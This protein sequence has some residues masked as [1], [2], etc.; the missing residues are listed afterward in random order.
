[1]GMMRASRSPAIAGLGMTDLGKVY[2]KTATQFAAEAVAL[3]A[4]DAGI[5]VSQ[6]DG[7]LISSGLKHRISTDLAQDLGLRD[8]SI[9]AEMNAFGATAAAM[10]QAAS[11]AVASGSARAV[12]CVFADTPLEEKSRAGAAYGDFRAEGMFGYSVA[13]GL[14]SAAAMY[15]LAARRHMEAYGT[16]KEQLGAVATSTRAWAATNERAQYRA[17][18]TLTDY[19]S[20]R[21]ISE[22][23]G[24]FDCC[25][26]S[27]GA[28]AVIV[29]STEL[30]ADGPH[31]AVNVV[32]WAQSHASHPM[33]TDPEFGIVTG[34]ATA[35]Q[36][37]FGRSGIAREE[38]DVAQLYDCFTYT[39]LV[40]AE[41]YGL[42]KKGEGGEFFAS[43]TTAPGGS[44]PIN[45]GGG[46]L[47]S[48]YMWGMTPL[49]EGI[50][51]ARGEGGARQVERHDMVLV[52][53]NGGLFDHHASL[54]LSPTATV[55]EDV[56]A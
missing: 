19:L 32:G 24:L 9:M 20:A 17:P 34:A 26:V 37:L 35:A 28:I 18:M 1:M 2:G 8:L 10:V 33:T 22:P 49:S 52:T 46:Q 30:A 39:P 31:P 27:N 7:L 44:L 41:D 42:C 36:R 3:A 55:R 56:F 25:L 23:F 54:L 6:L 47:S 45:T 5:A 13:A 16:T 40:T 51:Q 50:I 4:H 15:A 29:T 43:G 48:Y 14:T 53:G 12:A 21:V 11:L 38:V